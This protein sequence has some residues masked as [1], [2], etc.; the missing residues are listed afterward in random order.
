MKTSTLTLR[1]TDEFGIEKAVQM[2]CE[3]GFDCIDHSLFSGVNG[4]LY[5]EEEGY[6]EKLK[7]VKAIADSYGVKF[8]QTHAPFGSFKEGDDTYNEWVKPLIIKSIEATSILGAEYMVVHP[9]YVSVDKKQANM[10]FFRSLLPH[11][12]KHNVKLALENMFGWDPEKDVLIKNVC[13]DAE[14]LIDYVD[15]LDSEYAVVCLDVGH[16]GLVG[17]SAPDMIRKLGKERLR[18]LHIHDNDG[19]TDLH[20][21]PFSRSIDFNEITKALNEIGYEGDMTLEADAFY[22]G[23]PVELYGDVLILLSKTARYLAKMQ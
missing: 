8:N 23:F 9:F 5:I 15:S 11:A 14:E 3:A 16:C 19:I 4:S 12:K 6:L 17:E 20:T 2:I 18:C 10:E 13:S 1:L 7:A 21:I 22:K